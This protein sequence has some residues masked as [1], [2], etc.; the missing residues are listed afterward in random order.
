[1]PSCNWTTTASG[2]NPLGN[3]VLALNS[4]SSLQLRADI[5]HHVRTRQPG[6][7]ECRGHLEL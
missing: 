6:A 4:G 7:A 1:M 2:N 5:E 3:G